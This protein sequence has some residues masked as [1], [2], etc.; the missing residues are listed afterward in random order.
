M[1][2]SM[3]KRAGGPARMIPR[4]D[5]IETPARRRLRLAAASAW[6]LAGLNPR[7]MVAEIDAEMEVQRQEVRLIA[8]LG[9]SV[10]E[11]QRPELI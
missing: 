2:R 5:E 9:S 3:A 7:G 10:Y 8:D 1:L 4:L 6:H 11:V